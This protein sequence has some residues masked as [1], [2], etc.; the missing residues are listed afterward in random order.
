MNKSYSK[1][2]HIK[3]VNTRLNEQSVFSGEL[4]NESNTII[5]ISVDCSK[6]YGGVSIQGAQPNDSRNKQIFLSVCKR[7]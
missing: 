4:S 2:R 3:E 7:G 6:G 1:L 5:K